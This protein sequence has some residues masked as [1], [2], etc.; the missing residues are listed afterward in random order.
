MQRDAPSCI[1]SDND[2]L[3]SVHNDPHSDIKMVS[4]HEQLEQH[5]EDSSPDSGAED[6][7]N[8]SDDSDMESDQAGVPVTIQ[9]PVLVTT[10][11]PARTEDP[12][13]GWP[14]ALK[15]IP[16]TVTMEVTSRTCS[17][18]RENIRHSQ[19]TRV[20]ATIR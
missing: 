2:D 7:H 20:A 11:I 13:L 4:T 19:E 1:D 14:V 5:T 12:R 8:P 18:K 17:N 10:Q 6:S 3:V 16:A 9:I 15:P